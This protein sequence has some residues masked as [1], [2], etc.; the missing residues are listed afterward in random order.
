MTPLLAGSAELGV[1]LVWSHVLTR[2]RVP[3]I[4]ES[5]AHQLTAVL[6]QI[7]LR[8]RMQQQM[9]RLNC[10]TTAQAV[11]TLGSLGDVL[12]VVCVQ[13]QE[14]LGAEFARIAAPSGEPTMLKYIVSTGIEVGTLFDITPR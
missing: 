7:E 8:S 13:T 4:R 9:Q 3:F 6:G 14:L 11:T 5:F 2:E 10:S 1:L 12:N